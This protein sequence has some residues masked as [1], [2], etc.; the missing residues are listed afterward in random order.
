MPP[1][2]AP[3]TLR[4]SAGCAFS[5]SGPGATLATSRTAAARIHDGVLNDLQQ[6]QIRKA[7]AFDERIGNPF[8]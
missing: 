1:V 6:R 5:T 4:I 2:P 7:L 8:R 3:E